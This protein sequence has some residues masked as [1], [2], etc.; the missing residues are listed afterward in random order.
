MI[1]EGVRERSLRGLRHSRR[2]RGRRARRAGGPVGGRR[3]K[4]VLGVLAAVLLLAAGWMWL[5]DSPLVAVRKVTISGLTGAQAP[6]IRAALTLAARGMTT[7]GVRT[8][9]LRAAVSSYP[10]VKG[11]KVSAHFPHGLEITVTEQLPVVPTVVQLEAL[12]EPGPLTIAKLIVVPAGAFVNEPEPVL[13][14][15]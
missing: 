10:V 15:T 1:E 5:R 11:L 13:T 9:T 7:L 4:A 3:L 8:Q 12:R 14:F 6:R 2:P